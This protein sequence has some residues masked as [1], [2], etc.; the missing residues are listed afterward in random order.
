MDKLI[1]I[2]CLVILSLLSMPARANDIPPELVVKSKAVIDSYFTGDSSEF[3]KQYHP[4]LGKAMEEHSKGMVERLYHS[5]R[6]EIVEYDD[7]DNIALEYS[8]SGARRFD[9]PM[10]KR[11]FP[12]ME[13]KHVIF[14]VFEREKLTVTES[15]SYVKDDGKWYLVN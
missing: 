10:K 3:L 13:T 12:A 7:W 15:L 2:P 9:S 4:V 1:V 5:K 11:F 8:K 6:E 14:F